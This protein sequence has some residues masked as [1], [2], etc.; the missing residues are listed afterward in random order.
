MGRFGVLH[1]ERNYCR[2]AKY[3]ET[4]SRAGTHT[5]MH[6]FFRKNKNRQKGVSDDVIDCKNI[7]RDRLAKTLRSCQN[8]MLRGIK[9]K[10]AG[11]V[12][13]IIH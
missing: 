2:K 7:K 10:C 5:K 8:N 13:E 4:A 1:D 11:A 12:V 6:V 9:M 3:I